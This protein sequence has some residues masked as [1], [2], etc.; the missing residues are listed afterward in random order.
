M[1]D[2]RDG[3]SIAI[4]D[5]RAERARQM[6]GEGWTPEH[7]AGH[8]NGELA[9]AAAAYA[10][11]AATADRHYSADPIGFWPWDARWWKPTTP[12][13]DLVKAAALI[14]AEI[15]RLDRLASLEK[16]Q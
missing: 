11:S 4:A 2:L 10:F 12:R 7:D 14:V 5:I 6:H 16:Q 1:R 9:A 15:E 8:K 13:R 3:T